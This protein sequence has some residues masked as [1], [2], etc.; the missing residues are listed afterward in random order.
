VAK[1]GFNMAGMG[2]VIDIEVVWIFPSP[3]F[4]YCRR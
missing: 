2:R 4:E 3:S 1:I